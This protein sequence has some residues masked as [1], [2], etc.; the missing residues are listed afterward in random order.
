[1]EVVYIFCES[2]SVRIPF[3]NYDRRLFLLLVSAGGGVWDGG[4]REFVFRRNETPDRFRRIASYLPYVWVADNS[5]KLLYVFSLEEAQEVSRD[6]CS[7]GEGPGGDGIF[8][9][10]PPPV[11][12]K[13]TEHWRS[14]LEAEMRSRKLSP[15]TMKAYIY[16]NRLF[17]KTLQKPPEEIKPDDITLFLAAIEKKREYSASSLNLAISSIRFFYKNIFKDDTISEHYRP[18]HDKRLPLVLSKAEIGKILE[19]EKNPK[20]RLLLMLAYSS[21]LRVSEVVALKKEHIDLS[22]K[23]IYVVQ[24]KGRK[25]RCTLLSEKAAGFITEYCAFYGIE[26][27]LFPGQLPNRPLTIRSAQHIFDKAIRRAEIPK[28]I[29][30]HSLRHTFATHLLESGTDIRYIQNLLGH[31]HLRTTE[32]YT[33][34]AR[35]S[36][37]KIQS[38]LDTIE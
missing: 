12:E 6:I 2:A 14:K 29:S 5:R 15:R 10:P 21:G 35:R 24:G 31:V 30:I 26:T 1:M 36:V 27:W 16:Y 20:H 17:C 32:R 37:L 38:P 28:K 3:F 7:A 19:A 34:I 9:M 33:H 22:R 8:S 18:H 13:F 25:D 23:V 11:P 4:R